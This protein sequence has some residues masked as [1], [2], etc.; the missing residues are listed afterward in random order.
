MAGMSGRLGASQLAADL[1][2]QLGP[3]KT[4]MATRL[5]LPLDA[6]CGRDSLAVRLASVSNGAAVDSRALSAAQQP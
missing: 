2:T 6:L 1:R 5:L 4:K 3:V